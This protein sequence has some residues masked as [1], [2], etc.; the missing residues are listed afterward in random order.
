MKESVVEGTGKTYGRQWE[1]W[2]GFLR[3]TAG[4]H[5]PFLRDHK[6]EDKASRVAMFSK[7]RYEKGLR[8][9]GATAAAAAIRQAF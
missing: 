8:G 5:D 4:C 1:E 3:D 9:K 2:A 6:E 7:D